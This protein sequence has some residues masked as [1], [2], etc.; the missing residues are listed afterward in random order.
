MARR[1]GRP[2]QT[3]LLRASMVVQQIP[4]AL[5]DAAREPFLAQA[6]VY[7]LLL[8][9]DNEKTRTAQWQLLQQQIEPPLSEQAR[10][11][12]EAAQSLPAESRLPLVSL[13]V[14]SLKMA[15]PQQYQKFR[16]VVDALV[17]ADN[18]VDLFEYCLRVI[19]F[20][21]LDVV[22]G[23]AKPSVIRYRTIHALEKPAAVVLSL[24]AYVGHESAALAEQAYWAGTQELGSSTPPVPLEQCNL[25]RFD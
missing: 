17:G 10:R 11:L 15:S 1:V 14:P 5:A 12:A 4:Q 21:D 13:T 7:V 23:L 9:K 18:Q 8:S 16:Q 19:L 6:V 20:R 3:S 24:L 2:Q 25:G 22:F